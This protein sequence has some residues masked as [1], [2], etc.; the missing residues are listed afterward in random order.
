MTNLSGVVQ[1]LRKERARA[2]QAVARLEAALKAWGDCQV[3]E[4]LGVG[5]CL[6]PREQGLLPLSVRGG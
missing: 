6:L 1:Q 4:E 2:Q 3:Q 5:A